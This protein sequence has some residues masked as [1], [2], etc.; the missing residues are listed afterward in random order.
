MSIRSLA[1]MIP[2]TAYLAIAQTPARIECRQHPAL[3][4]IEIGG[5]TL[6]FGMP[7]DHALELLSRTS[8]QVTED[9]T[10]SAKHKPDSLWYLRIPEH[11]PFAGIVKGGVKF[12]AEKLDGAMV[13]WSPDSDEQ[14]DFAASLINLLERFSKEGLTSCTLST[15]KTTR[16]QQEDRDA[17]FQCGVRSVGVSHSRYQATFQGQKVPDYAGIY[18]MLGNW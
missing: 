11:Q 8:Y 2:L 7:K 5:Q 10:W 12:K 14:S 17:T 4:K 1:W 16:P 18:E 9:R 3:C 6:T 15:T 13:L